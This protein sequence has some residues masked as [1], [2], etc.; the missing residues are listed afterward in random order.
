MT[1]A[2]GRDGDGKLRDR[3]PLEKTGEWH[4]DLKKAPQAR[5]ELCRKQGMATEV[6]EKI[7]VHAH[8]LQ[9]KYLLPD[10]G[11][12]ALHFVARRDI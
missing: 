3:R 12:D 9:P 8:A 10:L 5:N 2:Q 1:L 6:R 7:V 4:F 11:D